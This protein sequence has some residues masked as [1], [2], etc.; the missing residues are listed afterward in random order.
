[1]DL[2]DI[3]NLLVPSVR[4]TYH[5]TTMAARTNSSIISDQ[6]KAL[7]AGITTQRDGLTRINNTLDNATI[8]TILI[9]FEEPL[10]LT[11]D[12]YKSV[13]NCNDGYRALPSF[14]VTTERSVRAYCGLRCFAAQSGLSNLTHARAL[15]HVEYHHINTQYKT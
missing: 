12:Y 2:I 10:H 9:P 6:G 8:S 7:S 3:D 11:A 13:C 15:K 1:M 14:C 5:K 4:A